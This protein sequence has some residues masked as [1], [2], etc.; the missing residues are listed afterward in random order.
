[1]KQ[2]FILYRRGEMFYCEDTTAGKQGSLRTKDEAEA[3]VLLSARNEATVPARHEP[4]NRP[5][6]FAGRRP[7]SG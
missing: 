5:G 1:M 2:R 3:K 7:D 6:L 4:A